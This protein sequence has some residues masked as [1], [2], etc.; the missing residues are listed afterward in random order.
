MGK[1]PT[2]PRPTV[3]ATNVAVL[4]RWRGCSAVTHI[5]HANGRVSKALA[6]SPRLK[7]Q[8]FAALAAPRSESAFPVHRNV[9]ERAVAESVAAKP[10]EVG[11]AGPCEPPRLK[12]V[13]PLA[14][15]SLFEHAFYIGL[16]SRRAIGRISQPA[17]RTRPARGERTDVAAF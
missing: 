9:G 4:S 12:R 13:P 7:S 14:A 1:T 2:R 3:F 16:G 6:I 10:F 15:V 5:A 11:H 8:G 17:N